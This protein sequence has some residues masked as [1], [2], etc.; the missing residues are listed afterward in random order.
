VATTVV[1]IANPTNIAVV[2]D[3][4]LYGA[5]E[6]VTGEDVATGRELSDGERAL[7][8]VGALA[9]GTGALARADSTTKINAA[10]AAMDGTKAAPT[11]ISQVANATSTSK[12]IADV[13]DNATAATT[14]HRLFRPDQKLTGS[15]RVLAG[16]T[17]A[18]GAGGMA[19][20]S[21]QTG[22]LHTAMETRSGAQ[23]IADTAKSTVTGVKTADKAVTATTGYSPL[24]EKEVSDKDRV[25]AGLG[26]V[27][28]TGTSAYKAADKAGDEIAKDAGKAM[29]GVRLE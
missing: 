25:K 12:K 29:D 3:N 5:V 24:K 11:V 9:S 18:A 15:E 14:G 27:T 22:K 13:A 20:D 23:K 4:V 17:A 19:A 21:T 26:A 2:A 7:G 10:V 1:T 28:D 8:V 6:G 16:V